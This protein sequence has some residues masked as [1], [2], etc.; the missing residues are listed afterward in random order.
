ML[1]R[2]LSL[3][4]CAALAAA[5]PTATSLDLAKPDDALTAFL[6]MRCSLEPKD[7]VV[8]WWK[9]TIFAQFPHKP[10]QAIMG[11]EGYNICRVAKQE[12]GSYQLLTRELS[13]YRDLKSGAILKT[14]TNPFN[15]KEVEVVHVANDPV[16]SRMAANGPRGPFVLPWQNQGEEIMFAFNVPLSYPNPLQPKDFPEESGGE[17]YVG[18]EHFMFFAPRAAVMDPEVKN[19]PL[20]YG[21]T[22]VG[23][24][25]PWMKMGTAAGNL[26]Y[27]AQGTKVT[28][29]DAL[30]AD[31]RALIESD[32]PVYAAAPE[33]WYQPNETSWTYYKKL[34]ERRR[35]DAAR[36][37]P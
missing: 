8:T 5:A 25:V 21:W 17:T 9:G 10:V 26:L 15:N 14:W 29:I 16:N 12:D 28:G 7:H 6:K 22:R 31:M 1:R 27:I 20:T 2:S 35:A 23:P 13:F 4:L 32:Y 3:L 37:S 30:P 18:S 24:W 19:T 11:F 33:T 34:K 36:T